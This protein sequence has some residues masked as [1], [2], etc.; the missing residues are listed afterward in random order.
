MKMRGLTVFALMTF[1]FL[2]IVTESHARMRESNIDQVEAHFLI[3]PVGARAAGMGNAFVAVADDGSA[4]FWNPGGLAFNQWRR[5][6]INVVSDYVGYYYDYDYERSVTQGQLGIVRPAQEGSVAFYSCLSAETR[7]KIIMEEYYWYETCLYSFALAFGAKLDSSTGVG[8]AVK[9]YYNDA[10]FDWGYGQKQISEGLTLDLGVLHLTTDPLFGYPLSLG[11]SLS[12]VGKA[13]IEN[14]KRDPFVLPTKLALG[15]GSGLWSEGN[16]KY[17]LAG[18]IDKLLVR[19]HSDGSFDPQ[20]VALFTSW[21]DVPFFYDMTYHIGAEY[22]YKNR[23]GLRIGYWNDEFGKTKP[24]TLGGSV[25]LETAN[26][27]FLQFD[28]SYW[29]VSEGHPFH[30]TTKF[31]LTMNF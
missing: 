22:W 9:Y 13:I 4:A 3:L 25:K 19:Q 31:S 23:V 8:A 7:H 18:E 16:H 10:G 5:I 30:R 6:T 14:K 21:T 26:K 29:I 24:I 17:T 28:M 27:S 1:T 15:F 2:P 11:L 20:Y 12:N